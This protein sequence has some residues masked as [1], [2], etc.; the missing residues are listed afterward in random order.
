MRPRTHRYA[1]H[2]LSLGQRDL[3]RARR[4][5]SAGRDH[6]LLAGSVARVLP[7]QPRAVDEGGARDAQTRGRLWQARGQP[8]PAGGRRIPHGCPSDLPTVSSCCPVGRVALSFEVAC[9]GVVLADRPQHVGT[10]ASQQ[11]SKAFAVRRGGD[12]RVNLGERPCGRPARAGEQHEKDLRTANGSVSFTL[13]NARAQEGS[14]ARRFSTWGRQSSA[15]AASSRPVARGTRR[16]RRRASGRSG[17]GSSGADQ[18]VAL[19]LARGPGP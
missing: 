7:L 13:V 5:Y 3:A 10:P 2:G 8:V 4:R 15:A 1:T 14:L 17:A 6:R 9:G 11:V 19:E 16:R 18:L 12:R